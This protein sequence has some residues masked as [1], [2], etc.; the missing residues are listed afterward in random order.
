[1]E[2]GDF[3]AGLRTQNYDKGMD[4]FVGKF[5]PRI[6]ISATIAIEPGCH[7]DHETAIHFQQDKHRCLLLDMLYGLTDDVF[8]KYWDKF[9]PRLAMPRSEPGK[10]YFPAQY[11]HVFQKYSDYLNNPLAHPDCCESDFTKAAMYKFASALSQMDLSSF[12]PEVDVEAPEKL[13]RV[14]HDAAVSRRCPVQDATGYW[15]SPEE[16]VTD[17]TSSLRSSEVGT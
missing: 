11:T 2:Q 4:R 16:A 9:Q 1:V 3:D 6:P 7:F 14:E 15:V 8:Q 5:D 12:I 13:C 17:G 10:L